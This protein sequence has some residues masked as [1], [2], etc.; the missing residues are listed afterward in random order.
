VSENMSAGGGF[1]HIS[2]AQNNEASADIDVTHLSFT[3]A[4]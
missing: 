1:Y 2:N 4:F 3:Y